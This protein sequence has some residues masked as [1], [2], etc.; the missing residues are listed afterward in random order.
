VESHERAG[1]SAEPAGGFRRLVDGDR[2][3]ADLLDRVARHVG[4][5]RLGE[6]LTAQAVAEDGD[7][8][9]EGVADQVERAGDPRQVVVHAHRSAHE[10]E[11][12][13]ARRVGGH[14]VAGVDPDQ[15]PV[16]PAFVEEAAEVTGAFGGGVA[17]DDDGFH[18]VGAGPSRRRGS[19]RP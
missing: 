9:G 6:Q 1:V 3:P 19:L 14:G 15:P 4:P 10:D 11:A 17:E 2:Q 16:D 7:I 8:A 5:E 12:G 13:K 18:G